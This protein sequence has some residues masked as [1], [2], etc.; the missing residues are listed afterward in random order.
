[1]NACGLESCIPRTK[2]KV[3]ILERKEVRLVQEPNR[4]EHFV[5]DQ[6]DAAAHGIDNTDGSGAERGNAASR[7][8][9]PHAS[10]SCGKGDPSRRYVV[11]FLAR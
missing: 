10:G 9:M 7:G 6:H 2:A 8:M 11:R 5:A 4:I 1:M 3:D